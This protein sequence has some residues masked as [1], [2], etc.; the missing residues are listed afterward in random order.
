MGDT[1]SVDDKFKAVFGYITDRGRAAKL[2]DVRAEIEVLDHEIQVLPDTLPAASR[3]WQ[4]SQLRLF[5]DRTSEASLAD[6]SNKNA[7]KILEKAEKDIA[8]ARKGVAALAESEARLPALQDIVRG[9]TGPELAQL[10]AMVADIGKKAKTVQDQGFLI[11]AIRARYDIDELSGELSSGALPRFYK[12]LGMVPPEHARL[13]D[14]LKRIHR[15][16]PDDTSTA[17]GGQMTI[18][19]GSSARDNVDDTFNNSAGKRLKLSRF[20]AVTLHEIGHTVDEQY[21]FMLSKRGQP[22]FGG[23]EASSLEEVIVLLSIQIKDS[24]PADTL[25]DARLAWVTKQAL[26]SPAGLNGIDRAVANAKA[27]KDLLRMQTATDEATWLTDATLVAADDAVEAFLEANEDGVG[28]DVIAAWA[29]GTRPLL[30]PIAPGPD[31]PPGANVVIGMLLQ[32]MIS[33]RVL[34]KRLGRVL[35]EAGAALLQIDREIPAEDQLPVIKNNVWV[36][37][38][39][40]MASQ[41]WEKS[42]A[43]IASVAMG[44]YVHQ[45]NQAVWWKYPLAARNNRV[46][47]YQFRSPLEWFAEVYAVFKLGK[48]SQ[49]HPCYTLINDIV[50]EPV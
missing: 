30:P 41:L 3:D 12:V 4:E 17:A 8:R 25:D 31:L 23:W 15:E 40:M 48:L 43:E 19:A 42:Q 39:T 7:Y 14:A 34:P 24:L 9:G 20:D 26:I 18:K 47:D 49:G 22:A 5:R 36:L 44:G 29:N 10:D 50:G 21:K 28:A 45:F 11:A 38:G 2:H 1:R 46:S 33:T 27:Q 32:A 13:N 37:R 16:K 35:A 6:K